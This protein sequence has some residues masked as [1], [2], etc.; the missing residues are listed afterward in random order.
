[1]TRRRPR[2]AGAPRASRYS[3]QVQMD[4][5][6]RRQISTGLILDS[7]LEANILPITSRCDSHCVFC[8]HKNN[9]PGIAVGVGGGAAPST[10]SPAPWPSWTRAA[11]ITIGESATPIIEGRA[12]LRTRGSGRSSRWCRRAFPETPLEITTNGELSHRE[13]VA[14][15]GA[16]GRDLPQR[17]PEQRVRPGQAAR[18]WAT[19]PTQSERTHRGRRGFSGDPRSA[20]A[21]AWWPCR[22]S[23]GWD[24]I[25]DTVVF[26]A[27]ERGGGSAGD[28]AGLLVL[29]R[30]AEA[31]RRRRAL[32]GQVRDFVDDARCR[33]CRAR[34]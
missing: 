18:S 32:H 20:S 22:T 16:T 23:S 27:D 19:A 2:R 34:C 30:G 5:P 8:S 9:P 26:L 31:R 15:P 33:V 6:H 24:D 21:A 12:L 29:G 14:V 13:M 4:I 1:M 25:R 11:S 3:L 10:R 28:R 7:A 17:L